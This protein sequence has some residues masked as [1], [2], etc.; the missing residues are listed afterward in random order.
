MGDIKTRVYTLE[1]MQGMFARG[2]PFP[3]GEIPSPPEDIVQEIGELMNVRPHGR[4]RGC[5]HVPCPD[6]RACSGDG[7]R[8]V[9]WQQ[10]GPGSQKA[11][12]WIEIVGHLMSLNIPDEEM[13]PMRLNK[14]CER[15][16]EIVERSD[17]RKDQLL[18]ALQVPKGRLGSSGRV[19]YPCTHSGTGVLACEQ[20]V[21]TKMAPAKPLK[22]TEAEFEK[23]LGYLITKNYLAWDD[24]AHTTVTFIGADD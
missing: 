8:V 2:E 16:M 12:A 22:L 3:E 17:I 4:R 23:A 20:E 24:D 9:V 21:D 5:L 6:E 15:M 18:A 19:T 11:K 14:A 7:I 13:H 10:S 1:E